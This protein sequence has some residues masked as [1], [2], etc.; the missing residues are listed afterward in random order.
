MLKRL[1]IILPIFVLTSCSEAGRIFID[2]SVE[3]I[4][5]GYDSA[6]RAQVKAPCAIS[7]GA[8]FRL[9]NPNLRRG[10]ELLCNPY[11]L[12]QPIAE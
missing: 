5:Y 1:I 7:A 6:A 10:V 4:E 3:K 9:G 8:Y 12:P 2:Q 11:I